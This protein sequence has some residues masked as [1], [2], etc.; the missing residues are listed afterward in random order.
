MLLSSITFL[1]ARE[2][3]WKAKWI[4]IPHS[5]KDTNIW[6]CYRKQ[7]KLNEVPN[8]AVTKIG[9]DSKYWLWINGKLVVFEGELRRGPNPNDTYYDESDIAKYLIKG[10]NI[11][12]LLEWYWGRDGYNHKSSTR[13]ALIF[14]S[15]V[16]GEVIKTDSSWKA[17]RHPSFG[18]TA[19]PLPNYRLP[20]FN[21][22]FDAGNF[23]FI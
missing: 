18:N 10:N 21:I 5:G 13:A 14:E 4:G 11:I 20:E 22:C 3:D 8:S 7:F 17:I 19:P 6:I 16:N 23:V 12:A 1:F 2:S 9:T 15:Y